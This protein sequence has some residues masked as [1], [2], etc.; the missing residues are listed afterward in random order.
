MS[1][2]ARF[3]KIAAVCT[4]ALLSACGGGGGGG[5]GG[6]PP[7]TDAG[8]LKV[9]L[10]DGPA[11]G[12]S[13]I[14]LTVQ[15][16]RV[17]QSATAADGDAGWSEIVLTPP[18]K[19]DLLSLTNG[20]VAELGSVLLPVGNY[21][22]MSLVLD[23]STPL[24]NSVVPFGA[25]ETPL[26]TPAGLQSGMKIP[27]SIDVA[28]GQTSDYLLD[29]DACNS[30]LRLGQPAT[31]YDLSL[32]Y[33]VVQRL[34]ATVTGFVALSLDPLTTRVSLQ[35]APLPGSVVPTIVRSTVPDSSGK[36]VLY[37][38]PAGTYNLVISEPSRVV[39][40]VTS[41]LVANSTSTTI[42]TSAAPIDPPLGNPHTASG[43]VTTG[44][45]PV[46]ARVVVIKRYLG[47][48]DVVFAGAPA[49]ASTGA[50]IYTVPAAAAIRATNL[51]GSPLGFSNDTTSPSGLF[52]I[53]VTAGGTTKTMDVD[54]TS[55]NPVPVTFT[56]P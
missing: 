39:T 12:Y 38:V 51:L 1:L 2:A 56:F 33:S 7:V 31:G 23:A 11:C 45:T 43:T 30:V 46:D 52:T 32:R 21:K 44:T 29:V 9:A 49:D 18:Q 48:P 8:T 28:S 16:V 53:A 20:A 27:I 19:I 41:V 47:G 13:H 36:F 22:Q 25:S 55:G 3:M 14:F 54:A 34:S 4:A 17:N 24:A 50:L 42:N 37:P 6:G 26:A 5:G 15:K 10:T 40:L 35:S